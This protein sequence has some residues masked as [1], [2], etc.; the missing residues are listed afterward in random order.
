MLLPCQ[1]F[2]SFTFS[3]QMVFFQLTNYPLM[4]HKIREKQRGL[5]NKRAT[6]LE[7]LYTTHR[8]GLF[9]H[10]TSAS[11]PLHP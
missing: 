7:L 5:Q 3:L 2:S 11:L 4:A 1:I 10:A 9:T 8:S 6:V